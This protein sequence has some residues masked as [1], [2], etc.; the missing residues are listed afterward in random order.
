LARKVLALIHH[1]LTNREQYDEVRGILRTV[2]LPKVRPDQEMDYDEIIQL[3]TQAGYGVRK[4][5][6]AQL[7]DGDEKR[8]IRA[9]AFYIQRVVFISAV[10]PATIN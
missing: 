4:L 2:N 9:D 6:A 5:N 8:P 3:L 1:L 7:S 10:E